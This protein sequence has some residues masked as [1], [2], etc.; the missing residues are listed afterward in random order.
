M[1]RLLLTALV[2]GSSLLAQFQQTTQDPR[3]PRPPVTG[4]Q[5][6]ADALLSK[7]TSA[8]PA[9]VRL[10]PG[11]ASAP[12]KNAPTDGAANPFAGPDFLLFDQPQADGPLWV[13][14]APWKASFASEG[15]SFIPFFGSDAPRNFPV[16]FAPP[17]VRIGGE[18]LATVAA[19]PTRTNRRIEYAHGSCVQALEVTDQGIEQTF[20]FDRLP[21]RGELVLS[22][23]TQS[24]LS[25]EDAGLG[26]TFGNQL[27]T[28]HYGEA[29]A[30]D[31]SGERTAAETTFHDGTI[32]IRVPALFVV[33]ARLPLLIDPL[34]SVRTFASGSQHVGNTDIAW[35]QSS[36]T[37]AICYQLAFSASDTD[38]FVVRADT[39]LNLLGLATIDGTT[40]SW[41]APKIASNNGAHNFLVVCQVNVGHV[42]PHWIGGR[43]LDHFGNTGGQFDIERSGVAGHYPGN[44]VR[45]DVGG[46]PYLVSPSYFTVVWEHEYSTADHDILMKQVTTGGTLR[47]AAPTVIDNSVAFQSHPSIG[48]SDGPGPAN[49]QRW[50]IVYQQTYSATDEDLYGALVTWDGQLVLVGGTVRQDVDRSAANTTQP[51]VSSPTAGSNRI[52]L[53]ASECELAYGSIRLHAVD[54]TLGPLWANDVVTIENDALRGSWAKRAPSIDCDGVRFTV[55]YQ[56]AYNNGSD[57]DVRGSLIAFDPT[58]FLTAQ[59]VGTGFAATG[60]IELFPEVAS[61]YSGSGELSDRYTISC[62][63]GNA[64]AYEVVGVAYAGHAPG[65][66]SLRSTGCGPLVITWT[67]VPL[68]GQRVDFSLF[69]AQALSGYVFGLPANN[70]LAICPGCTAGVQGSSVLGTTL[71]LDIPP[72][73]AL[74]GVTVSTQGFTFGGGPCL[75]QISLSDTLDVRIQ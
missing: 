22:I 50:A 36:Q 13:N 40:T 73:A 49:L 48:K 18:A 21:H 19:T 53:V 52:Y 60:L 16:G 63:R 44:H 28:V 6:V 55:A 20:R 8:L 35:D 47:S 30:I 33:S 64:G 1:P 25:G 43:I 71:A 51:R 45:P 29:V 54:S 11:T 70:P 3:M 58:Q 68:L 14:T 24:E 61:R 9:A 56:E 65:G 69:Q 39:D 5:K 38:C 62:Q 10:A 75:G 66:I 37:S 42:A 26:L 15:W 59:E 46:D 7:P 72:A 17:N 67:G 2:L 32:T 31:A 41:T 74:V 57:W 23:A 4:G 34:V 12:A 27:G